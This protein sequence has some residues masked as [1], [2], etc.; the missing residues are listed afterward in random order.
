[1]IPRFGSLGSLGG[2]PIRTPPRGGC[3]GGEDRPQGGRVFRLFCHRRRLPLVCGG[4]PILAMNPT[5][6]L[7][8]VEVRELIEGKRYRELREAL[9]PMPPFDVAAVLDLLEPAEAAVAFRLLP[10]VLAG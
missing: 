9:A 2:G 8:H 1:M 4:A 3:T 6:E 7:L 10:R 5:A